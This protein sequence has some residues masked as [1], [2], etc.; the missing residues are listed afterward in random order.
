M[1]VQI[2][3][4]WKKDPDPIGKALSYEDVIIS[5]GYSDLST[6]DEVST[7]TELV[8]GISLA[9]PIVSANMKDVTEA[10][11]AEFMARVGGFGVIHRSMSLEEQVNQV[12]QVK[13]ATK[14]VV[15]DPPRLS[16]TDTVEKARKVMEERQRGFVMVFGEDETLLGLASTR[17]LGEMAPSDM[18][19]SGV[20]TPRESI[21]FAP[22]GISME[23][24]QQ[25]MY[26][27]RIEKLPLIDGEGNVGGVITDRD[28]RSI[29]KYPFATKDEEGRLRVGAAIGLH[30]EA[31]ERAQALID[32]GVDL[33]V[34]DVLHGDQKRVEEM[35]KKVKA[36]PQTVPVMAGNV[37]RANSTRRLIAAGADSVKVGY[38]P[39][40]M[41][42][43]QVETGT[44]SQQ[45]S[46]VV[47][48]AEA[49]YNMNS[50]VTINADGGIRVPGDYAKAMAAGADHVMIGT[51][52]AGTDESP[53]KIRRDDQTGD[54]YK[55]IM[56]MA[57]EEAHEELAKARG[58]VAKK[59]SPQGTTSRVAY[60]GP[61]EE[62]ITRFQDGLRHAIANTGSRSIEEFQENAIFEYQTSAG[63]REGKPHVHNSS[64]KR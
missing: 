53:G 42:T 44:G 46:A 3:R 64:L 9:V 2:A 21:V 39:G 50:D 41:C 15:T 12:K 35:I 60:T 17:D 5:P 8:K 29:K 56:G 23:E 57:S 32:A 7:A 25:L 38:G 30:G 28:I 45:F 11:M 27:H 59:R 33:L 24:A 63:Q 51:L 43:T 16:P 31:L 1:Y 40:H 37:A 18:P 14:F 54:K 58:G 10:P 61:A 19:L 62:I 36:L 20:M 55:T 34:I 13:D 22:P 49:V 4:H 6:V 26:Q 47:K 52:L 48:S